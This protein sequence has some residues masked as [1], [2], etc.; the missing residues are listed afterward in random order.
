MLHHRPLGLGVITP[1]LL[2]MKAV[3]FM[4]YA[5]NLTSATSDTLLPPVLTELI[6]EWPGYPRGFINAVQVVDN[7]AFTAM[8]GWG[9]VIYDVSNPASIRQV[10]ACQMAHSPRGGLEV[11]TNGMVSYLADYRGGIDA[12]DTTIPAQPR[13]L[14]RRA[15]LGTI[16][17]LQ[18]NGN[19]LYVATFTHLH[20]LDASRPVEMEVLGSLELRP[21][22]H[23][24]QAVEN[25]VCLAG[26]DELAVLDASNPAQITVLGRI[27]SNVAQDCVMRGSLVYG[28]SYGGNTFS[29][30]DVSNPY[31]MRQMGSYTFTNRYMDGGVQIKGDLAYV[32]HSEGVEILRI[33]DPAQ[34]ELVGHSD[35]GGSGNQFQVVDR[36]VFLPGYGFNGF[37]VLDI[38]DP[39]Q[40]VELATYQLGGTANRMA[41]SDG[42]AYL[43][44]TKEGLNILDVTDPAGISVLG[45]IPKDFG[46]HRGANH[47]VDIQ[48]ENTLAYYAH[49]NGFYVLDITDPSRPVILGSSTI[50]PTEGWVVDMD[51]NG[52]NLLLSMTATVGKQLKLFRVSNFTNM[53]SRTLSLPLSQGGSSASYD[54]I[55]ILNDTLYSIRSTDR[56][57]LYWKISGGFSPIMPNSPLPASARDFKVQN[58]LA[59]VVGQRG[60]DIINLSTTQPPANRLI[61][62]Y[63]NC[64]SAQWIHVDG[65]TAYVSLSQITTEILDVSNPNQILPLGRLDHGGDIRVAHDKIYVANQG[66][67][68]KVYLYS[69]GIP[70][71]RSQPEP[72]SATEGRLAEFRVSVLGPEPLAYQWYRGEVALDG[73]TSSNL[74]FS[75]VRPEQAGSYTVV[76]SSPWGSVTSR[77]VELSVSSSEPVDFRI[78][79][80]QSTTEGLK[81]TFPS[82]MGNNYRLERANLLSNSAWITCQTVTG[83]G[84]DLVLI[85]TN[86]VASSAFYRVVRTKN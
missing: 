54:P 30:I 62:S 57:F 53:T 7:L 17:D 66:G 84:A 36:S 74:V 21:N 13:R 19:R 31:Q 44:D 68:L 5:S 69:R 12:I 55:Q 1:R 43:T 52:T 72:V 3:L 49:L 24:I 65:Q 4:A 15:E 85:D 45:N 86:H 70:A 81:I 38:S 75:A 20:V 8:E 64:G 71:F 83:T 61:G 10:G 78:T 50:Q 35:L 60:L 79:Q 41:L 56:A 34:L 80:V 40:V 14:G 82:M 11:Q 25:M 51:R 37:R 26:M 67:G 23:V 58:Q 73:A 42:K 63:T 33:T 22:Y 47:G 46:G 18:V 59:Y 28:V 76:A 27:P 6:G 2:L 29:I 32:S 48:V 16:T 9:L 77:K 39:S